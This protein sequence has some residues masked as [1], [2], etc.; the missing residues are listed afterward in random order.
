MKTDTFDNWR[1]VGKFIKKGA[2]SAGRNSD[3][4]LKIYSK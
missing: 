2:K 3:V 1:K 4:I